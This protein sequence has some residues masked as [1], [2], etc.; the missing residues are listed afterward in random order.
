MGAKIFTTN[1]DVETEKLGEGI[2]RSLRSKTLLLLSGDLGS[3]KTTFVK[4]LAVGVGVKKRITSPTFTLLKSYPASSR[5]TLNHI[6]LYR[7]SNKNQIKSLGLEDIINNE[8]SIT[9][10]E[11]AEK[12]TNNF[13]KLDKLLQIRR[14]NF[15]YISEN[16]RE[17][18]IYE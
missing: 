16:Q 13:I 2:G 14:I 1:S 10:I 6:D 18:K 4:G 17:I 5:I 3:G 12:I 7:F 15:K 8:N 11:W 9:V